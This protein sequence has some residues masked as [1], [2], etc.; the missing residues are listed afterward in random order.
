MQSSD[1]YRSILC[2]KLLYTKE[3]PMAKPAI[4]ESLR[5]LRPPEDARLKDCFEAMIVALDQIQP[6]QLPPAFRS[7]QESLKATIDHNTCFILIF[8][9][10]F[11][12]IGLLMIILKPETI[13]ALDFSRLEVCPSQKINPDSGKITEADLIYKVPI[14]DSDLIFTLFIVLEHKSTNDIHVPFQA[15]WYSI[16]QQREYV[17][18]QKA[19]HAAKRQDVKKGNMTEQEYQQEHQAEVKAGQTRYPLPPAIAIL[20]HQGAK[21]YHG[22]T[23]TRDMCPPVPGLPDYYPSQELMVFELNSEESI[24]KGLKSNVPAVGLVLGVYQA[25]YSPDAPEKLQKIFKQMQELTHSSFFYWLS[26]LLTIYSWESSV[27]YKTDQQ[28]REILSACTIVEQGEQNMLSAYEE[29]RLSGQKD[30]EI[31]GEARGE[32]RG[33]AMCKAEDIIKLLKA[34]RFRVSP[35]LQTR[36][37]QIQDLV[38]LDSLFQAAIECTTLEEFKSA[39]Y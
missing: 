18:A 22:P 24:E 35:Q 12:A 1:E 13:A 30:G 3:K 11:M 10:K 23:N 26:R 37:F 9:W 32:A 38:V 5:S 34:K 29:A 19:A 16:S 21:P 2:E 8:Q 14:K 7:N 15:S 25:I 6:D 20:V 39:L 27:Y 4:N 28:K 31:R 17:D 33:R 36:I